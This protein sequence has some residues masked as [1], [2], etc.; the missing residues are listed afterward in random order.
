MPLHDYRCLA[1]GVF[2]SFDGKCPSG[3]DDSLVQ[4]VFLKPA[5]F[6]SA[7]TV[8]IDKTLDQLA[9]D[10]NMTDMNNQNGTS[11]AARPDPKKIKE[12]QEQLDRMTYESNQLMGKL[13]DTTQAWGQIP[14]GNTGVQQAMA[15]VKA[16]GDNALAPLLPSLTGPKA[17]VVASYNAEIKP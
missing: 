9:L 6:H 5:G 12:R 11:A 14:N 4:K 7:R 16:V 15:Q 8:N 2:E 13:G 3:C 10:F 1:H 17:N